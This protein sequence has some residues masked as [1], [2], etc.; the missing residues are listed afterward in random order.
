MTRG[1]SRRSLPLTPSRGGNDKG[2]KGGWGA[3]DPFFRQAKAQGYAARSV[4]KL[5]QLDAR[6]G[7]VRPRDR[8]LDLGCAPGSWLQYLSRRLDAARGC[9]VGVD[10]QAVKV[11]KLGAHVHVLRADVHDV[12]AS[13]L[14]ATGTPDSAP[15]AFDAVLSDMAP[16]T[17]GVKLVDQQRSLE[18][19][20]RA[21]RL[22]QE[23]LRPGG[24]L[25]VKVFEGD[26]LRDYRHR[27]ARLFRR[28]SLHRPEATKSA[29]KEIYVV[30]LE[31]LPPRE[32]GIIQ[33]LAVL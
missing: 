6:F 13:A 17:C 1:D 33:G 12:T 22:A 25:C 19:C 4:F 29:S 26:G 18:L 20:E 2:R 21:L 27:C 32:R 30:A 16:A 31:F 28:V 15:R 10:L 24:R 8:V 11:G 3:R 5:Q 7:L 14:L 9:A 23:V